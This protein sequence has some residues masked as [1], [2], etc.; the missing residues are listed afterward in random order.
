LRKGKIYTLKG[1]E[2]AAESMM[3]E[4][5]SF[6][7]NELS[8]LEYPWTFA[9]AYSV[10]N[11]PFFSTDLGSVIQNSRFYNVPPDSLRQPQRLLTP[12]PFDE[13]GEN[14]SAVLRSLRNSGDWRYN[15]VIGALSRIVKGVSDYSVR[16]SGSFLVTYLNYSSSGS[17]IRQSDLGLESDG[18]LRV[19]S[20]LAAL[21]QEPPP[22][23]LCIE[24]P[25][26]HV[27]PGVLAVLADLFKEA[28][29]RA[30][31]LLT[32]HSPDLLDHFPVDALRVVEK[33]E[34][35]T[36]VGSVSERQR[37]IV[38]DQLFLPGELLRTEGLHREEAPEIEGSVEGGN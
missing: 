16:D 13:S 3:D 2:S 25:E 4:I 31:V 22:T 11:L 14:L 29:E 20:I 19:L 6:S 24:E 30:P 1:F 21:Y 28:A 34:G 15:N 12:S 8:L 17:K 7:S 33:I 38:R 37:A 26:S 9:I 35:A 27:H 18:T 5:S 36:Q 23:L 32:T 10:L